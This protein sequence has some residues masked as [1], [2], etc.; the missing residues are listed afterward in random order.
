MID[1]TAV[2]AL[3]LNHRQHAAVILISFHPFACI[4]ASHNTYRGSLKVFRFG[5]T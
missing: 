4:I 3:Y 2:T 1:S 5:A